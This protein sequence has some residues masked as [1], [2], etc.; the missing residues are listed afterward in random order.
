M[1][2]VVPGCQLLPRSLNSPPGRPGVVELPVDL[3]CCNVLLLLLCMSL[4]LL[5]HGELP[6]VLQEAR[7]RSW[8]SA[9]PHV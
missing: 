1:C 3:C 9:T 2:A 4:P 8:S 7:T 5:L 6:S